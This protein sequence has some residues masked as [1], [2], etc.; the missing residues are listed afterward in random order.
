MKTLAI[1]LF[2][3][4][5]GAGIL[6]ISNIQKNPDPGIAEF[7]GTFIIPFLL[8]W[9]GKIALDRANAA[10][11]KSPLPTPDTHVR[12][13]ECRELVIMDA[14]VC[15]HCSAKLVPAVP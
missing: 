5:G 11:A 4:A 8:G 14:K 2:L 10:A 7:L 1:V 9:W 15:K 6:G 3:L 13:P 12:C